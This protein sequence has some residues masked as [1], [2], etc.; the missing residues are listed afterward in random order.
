MD[1]L[2]MNQPLA[3][4][5]LVL[6]AQK[7]NFCRSRSLACATLSSGDTLGQSHRE[8]KRLVSLSTN[9]NR[10]LAT[11]Q[12]RSGDKTDQTQTGPEDH[13]NPGTGVQFR[14]YFKKS[15]VKPSSETNTQLV[16][17]SSQLVEPRPVGETEG[18]IFQLTL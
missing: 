2:W 9:A 15:N 7:C 3:A 6:S 14:N 18:D 1:G 8:R 16:T 12:S 5:L 13:R 17:D 10:G 4:A 11:R